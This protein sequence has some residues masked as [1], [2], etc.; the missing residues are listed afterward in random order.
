MVIPF[1][2]KS[3]GNGNKYHR[4]KMV[5]E[6]HYFRNGFQ[7]SRILSKMRFKSLKLKKS[8]PT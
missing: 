6:M 1:H 2:A 7:Y 5:L 3:I 4:Q 8:R